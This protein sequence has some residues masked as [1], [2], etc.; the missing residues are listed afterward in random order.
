MEHNHENTNQLNLENINPITNPK[1]Q[2]DANLLAGH[3]SDATTE[4]ESEEMPLL[5]GNM[6]K[7]RN[8][9]EVG[10]LYKKIAVLVTQDDI[11]EEQY[12]ALS[13]EDKDALLLDRDYLN[14]KEQLPEKEEKK[15]SQ[16][17]QVLED[18]GNGPTG[19]YLRK[20]K[21]DQLHN[22]ILRAM[23]DL[24]KLK[25]TMPTHADIAEWTGIHRNTVSAHL[26]EYEDSPLFASQLEQY[27]FAAPAV[28]DGI[29][30]RA[31]DGDT[32]AA[33]VYLDAL[34]K[35]RS[36]QVGT[37]KKGGTVVIKDLHLKQE[38]ID[39]LPEDTLNVLQSLLQEVIPSYT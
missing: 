6:R 25:Q 17:H 34:P 32:R 1:T 31:L 36:W 11:T 7:P 22:T 13:A 38:D 26:R 19:N 24:I 20:M 33:K 37:K 21:W 15:T 30:V 35:I 4:Q 29:M 28:I 10:E 39:Q 2:T 23:G 18:R 16:T 5:G 8:M 3:E 27:Q 14:K 12:D 9:Q